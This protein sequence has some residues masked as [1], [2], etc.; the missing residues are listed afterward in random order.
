[1][2]SFFLYFLLSFFLPF[3]ISY[4]LSSVPLCNDMF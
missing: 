4:F 3:N 1:L 2:L